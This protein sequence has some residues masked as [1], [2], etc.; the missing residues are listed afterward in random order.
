[1]DV[2][3]NWKALSASDRGR[4]GICGARRFDDSLLAPSAKSAGGK[5]S[6]RPCPWADMG[7]NAAEWV[8]DCWGN[9]VGTANSL[10][11]RRVIATGKGSREPVVG[12]GRDDDSDALDWRIEFKVFNCG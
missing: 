1:M 3:D 10:L 11:R 8:E 4:V 7:G 12:T 6:A 5:T 9:D 2:K